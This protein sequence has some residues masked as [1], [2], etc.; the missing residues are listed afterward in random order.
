MAAKRSGVNAGHLALGTSI[1]L[2]RRMIGVSRF[3]ANAP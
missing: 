2:L 3:H 1:R